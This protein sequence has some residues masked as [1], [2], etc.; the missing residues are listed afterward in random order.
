MVV[1][2][3]KEEWEKEEEEEEEEEKEEVE[4]EDV[5]VHKEATGKQ[6]YNNKG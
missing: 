1:Y 6:K 5:E 4:E 3:W 2:V